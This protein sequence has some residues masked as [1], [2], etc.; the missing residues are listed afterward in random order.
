[1]QNHQYMDSPNSENTFITFLDLSS[2]P[3]WISKIISLSISELVTFQAVN[4]V[5][6]SLWALIAKYW[7][8]SYINNKTYKGVGHNRTSDTIVL[9]SCVS[10]PI[11]DYRNQLI[12]TRFVTSHCQYIYL[13]DI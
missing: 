12:L 8:I 4:K 6:W 5:L 13:W 3:N 1:M 10:E 2:N 7:S 11:S 9:N